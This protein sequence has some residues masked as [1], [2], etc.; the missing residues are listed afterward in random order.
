MF[1]LVAALPLLPYIHP[2]MA[3]EYDGASATKQLEPPGFMGLNYGHRTP[4]TTLAGQAVYGAVL[5]GLPQLQSVL[6]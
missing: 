3:S 6:T 1:L 5:G 4:L 2:R